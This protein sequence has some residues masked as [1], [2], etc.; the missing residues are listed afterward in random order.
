MTQGTLDEQFE[1]FLNTLIN[2]L[3]DKSTP[4]VRA[5]VSGILARYMALRKQDQEGFSLEYLVSDLVGILSDSEIRLR[6]LEKRG[7]A[8]AGGS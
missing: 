2:Q 6:D 8:D 4:S 1:R 5:F 7:D 3:S